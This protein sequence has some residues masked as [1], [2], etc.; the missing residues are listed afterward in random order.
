MAKLRGFDTA[1]LL[2]EIQRRRGLLPKLQRRRQQL[3]GQLAAL[4]SQIAGL[5]GDGA[6]V[7]RGPGRPP[8]AAAPEMAGTGTGRRRRRRG[9]NKL[10]LADVLADVVKPDSPMNVGEIMDAVQK[11][12]YKSSSGQFRN[13][14]SQRLTK[15]K[16][17][18]RVGRGQYVRTG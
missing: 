18:K 15:D 11:R 8:K 14:V 16:R 9:R 7:R 4:D 3:A 12:G 1:A 10:S 13:I 2:A 17:F 6:P 5:D